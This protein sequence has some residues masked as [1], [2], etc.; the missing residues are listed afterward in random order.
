[1]LRFKRIRPERTRS[2]YVVTATL[3]LPHFE[4]L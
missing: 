3:R 1:M 4:Q 2:L